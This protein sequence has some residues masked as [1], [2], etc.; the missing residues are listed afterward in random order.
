MK[1]AVFLLLALCLLSAGS[2]AQSAPLTDY[3]PGQLIDVGFARPVT[4]LNGC[5]LESGEGFML[6]DTDVCNVYLLT[7]TGRIARDVITLGLQVPQ[8]AHAEVIAQS[9]QRC[10]VCIQGGQERQT[11]VYALEPD[12]RGQNRWVLDSYVWHDGARTC[13]AQF[14]GSEVQTTETTSAGEETYTAYYLFY[15]EANNVDY[16]KIPHSIAEAKQMEKQFPV[17]AV[18][19][20]DPQSRVNLRKAPSTKAERVG[21]LYSGTRLWIR[22]FTDD[23][24]AKVNIGDMDAYIRTDFLTFGEAIGQVPDARPTA[25]LPDQEFVEVSRQP[26]RGGGGTMT[27]VYGGQTVRVIGEYNSGWRIIQ[28]DESPGAMFIEADKLR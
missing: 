24:W 13:T 22:E 28:M 10:E 7:A 6:V 5:V 12:E 26:Y 3:A 25:K 9:E 20:E 11:Y 27:R 19:P 23:G 2:L 8:G 15:R 17:A 18:S 21:S 1:R 14:G 16:E 4:F